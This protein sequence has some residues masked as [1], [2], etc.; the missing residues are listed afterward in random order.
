MKKIVLT[1]A[2]VSILAFSTA[3]AGPGV[4]QE[5][6][7]QIFS[8]GSSEATFPV[9]SSLGNLNNQVASLSKQEMKATEGE[10][11]WWVVAAVVT[12]VV[13]SGDSANQG[14]H[15]SNNGSPRYE[16]EPVIGYGFNPGWFPPLL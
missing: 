15:A 9:G 3:Q 5:D 6:L 13:L 16:E 11:W 8:A 1:T 7:N 12:T 10:F 2:L 14:N 4:P